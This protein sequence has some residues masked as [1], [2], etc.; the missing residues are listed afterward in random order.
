M[1]TPVKFEQSTNQLIGN[2]L[3]YANNLSDEINQ[4]ANSIK[5]DFKTNLYYMESGVYKD[6]EMSKSYDVQIYDIKTNEQKKK[7]FCSYPYETVQFDIGNYLTF[8]YGGESTTWLITSIDKANYYE[9]V[10]EI[11]LC[12]WPLKWQDESGTILSYPC[13]TSNRSFDEKSG[14]VITLPSNQK[15]ILLPFNE[16]TS[17]L[18]AD[19]RFFVDRKNP[20]TPYK[21]IGDTDTTSFNYGGKGLIQ[22]LVEQDVLK[23]TGE[24]IDNIELGICGYIKPTTLPPPIDKMYSIITCSNPS[25]QITIGSSSGRTL[26]PL[27]YRDDVLLDD[28]VAVWSYSLPEGFEN[29]FTISPVSGT[30]KLKII[31]KDNIKL[32]GKTLVITVSNGSGEY[33]SS[34]TLTIVSGY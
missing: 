15:Y 28:I 20:P 27:F 24:I 19:K 32:L 29:Q 7:M 1:N 25:N 31:V 3:G 9:V 33:M 16:H 2:I 26:T 13:V 6:L 23:T 11:K 4:L 12:N 10:G 34:I 17:K 5:E 14:T 18:K 30:N 22:I 21:I 8:V